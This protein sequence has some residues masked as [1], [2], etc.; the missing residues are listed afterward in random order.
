MRRLCLIAATVVAAACHHGPRV[1]PAPDPVA[2]LTRARALLRQ[3]KFNKALVLFRRLAYEIGPTQPEMAEV[4]YDLAECYFQTGDRVQAAHDFRQVADQFPTSDY[5]ALALLRA[6]DANVR[7]WKDPELD[8]SYGETALAIYQ[9]L[10]GR[11][12]GTEAAARGQVH[13]RQLREWFSQKDYKNG[14]FY[15]KRR[16]FDSAIIYFK[17]V[18]ANYAGTSRV[19]DAL[20]R[21]VDSYRVI[22]Y[23]DELKETCEHLRRFF[24]QT[25]GLD[26]SCPADSSAAAPS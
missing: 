15:F 1:M 23:A 16:A 11:Y 19:P 9:E 4:Q 12:P 8:P 20:M 10:G 5:A 24:P 7:L 2:D 22:G 25:E 13:V 6:G 14:M 17:D 21:L 26:K 18:I 3:G